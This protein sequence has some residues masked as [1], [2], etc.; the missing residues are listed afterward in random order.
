MVIAIY[1][2]TNVAEFYGTVQVS[3]NSVRR[4][5]CNART[6]TSD[7]FT[8]YVLGRLELGQL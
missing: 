1:A 7:E 8:P 3:I 5:D 4:Q 2:P 6:G